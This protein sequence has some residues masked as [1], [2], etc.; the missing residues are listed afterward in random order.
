MKDLLVHLAHRL[1]AVAKLPGTGG[2]RGIVADSLL[3]KQQR[4]ISRSR[5]RAPTRAALDGFPLVFWSLLFNPHRIQRAAVIFSALD[6]IEI[7]RSTQKRGNASDLERKQDNFLAYYNVY[8]VPTSLD[9]ST[10]SATQ[11]KPICAALLSTNSGGN[12]TAV[13]YTRCP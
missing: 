8:R 9:G 10:P 3:M 1:T 2:A 11:A 7:S 6:T 4:L 5:R 13:G 12:L